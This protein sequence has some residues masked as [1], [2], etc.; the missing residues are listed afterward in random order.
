M[1]SHDSSSK[2]FV[3][4]MVGFFLLQVSGCDFEL[5]LFDFAEGNPTWGP[6]VQKDAG[7]APFQ[8]AGESDAGDAGL[9]AGFDAGMPFDAGDAGVFDAGPTCPD[10]G[11]LSDDN[12]CGSCGFVC[13]G[14]GNAVCANGLCRIGEDDRPVNA[15][16][17]S[18]V[19][20]IIL[21]IGGGKVAQYILSPAYN[22]IIF[23]GVKNYG[24]SQD[25]IGIS[26]RDNQLGVLVGN[27]GQ[28]SAVLLSGFTSDAEDNL[29]VL[30]DQAGTISGDEYQTN[31]IAMTS[32]RLW[33]LYDDGV[34]SA[35]LNSDGGIADPTY[36]ETHNNLGGLLSDDQFMWFFDPG[37][38]D[39]RVFEDSTPAMSS[40]SPHHLD[41][42]SFDVDSVG[43]AAQDNY[44]TNTAQDIYN[45]YYE[46]CDSS[47]KC[48]IYSFKKRQGDF[49]SPT[50]I[51]EV[52]A[53]NRQR[54]KD[55]A[56]GTD[57]LFVL[58]DNGT[59]GTSD[60]GEINGNTRMIR[61][62]SKTGG[63]DVLLKTID[64]TDCAP[65]R[66][67]EVSGGKVFVLTGRISDEE[68]KMSLLYFEEP[69]E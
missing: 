37:T 10:S 1:K 21:S 19:N 32:G 35:L 4:V 36:W 46:L 13:T 68:S 34:G 66:Q 58:L 54:I 61:G 29:T 8:D 16:I 67:I 69:R 30:D 28:N 59:D 14:G 5:R 2:R 51:Y 6:P 42:G 41:A 9:N 43:A 45:L 3:V 57:Y 64:C 65:A 15:Q 31:S 63:T 23:S 47:S 38:D 60:A 39:L 24:S 48:R 52:N 22:N 17:T 18:A 53:E 40:G 56:V 25:A 62:I 12:N 26:Y 50:K 20:R 33:Y 27:T 7:V 11:M 44:I 49:L 55:I